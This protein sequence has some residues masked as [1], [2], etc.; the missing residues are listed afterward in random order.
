MF[1]GGRL[2]G[3]H[4]TCPHRRI[5]APV[6]IDPATGKPHVWPMRYA[7][8]HRAV[9]LPALPAG[10]YDLC[11]RAID[12]NGIA[13]PMPRPPPRTGANA[14]QEATLTAKA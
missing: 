6:Q 13:Q 11:C 10:K 5:E 14:I 4:S 1:V 2:E 7:I 8:V 12:A 9:L 3:S